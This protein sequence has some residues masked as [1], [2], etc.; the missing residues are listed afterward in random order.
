MRRAVLVAGALVAGGALTA[1]ALATTPGLNGLIAFTAARTTGGDIYTMP[2]G[3]DPE[4]QRTS[5]VEA[6]D[7]AAWSPDGTRFAF[8]RNDNGE[9]D[10][11]IAAADGTNVVPFTTTPGADIDP[12]WSPDGTRIAW[13]SLRDGSDLEIFSARLDGTGLVQHTN[14]GAFFDDEPAWSPDG[15]AIAFRSGRSM[16]N[17]HR[18]AASGTEVD[19]RQV[20]TTPGNAPSWSPDGT[21]IAFD[22]VR[23]GAQSNIFSL[24]AGGTP[25]GT[26][27]AETDLRRHTT[28]P[29]G[30]VTPS[31]SPDGTRIAFASF[32]TSNWDIWTTGYPGTENAPVQ[33]TTSPSADTNPSWQ[34][35]AALPSLAAI[36]PSTA[37]AGS[38]ALTLTV[39][40]AG[41]TPRSRV[42]WQ[43]QDRATTFVS[44]TRLTAAIPASDLAGPGTAQV[45]VVTGPTGGG[46]SGQLPFTVQAPPPAPGLTVAGAA[47]QNRW[48]ASRL[49]GRLV[50]TGA[51]TRPAVLR[52]RVLRPNGRGKALVTRTFRATA[53]GPFTRRL[54][55]APTLLPGRYL[56]RLTEVGSGPGLLPVAE[57]RAVV[58][59]PREGVAARAYFSTKI[60]GRALTRIRG[61]SIIFA[62][63]RMAARPKPG[64]RLTV[65]WYAPGAK[66]PAAV[67]RKPPSA[68][69]IAFIKGSGPLPRGA[70]RAVLRYG[71]TRVATARVVV[72]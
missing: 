4:T 63:F 65:S 60:N 28:D 13:A 72:R 44:S 14:N 11:F 10:I 51:V 71:T 40:G 19:A 29:N 45:T 69:V 57:R 23:P 22:S 20:T 26:A 9:E 17:I 7:D 62:H 53:A 34:T 30:A 49:R 41:F 6:D 47:V 50:L 31:W 25:V 52:V 5:T 56:V 8:T 15:S 33:L 48:T 46:T 64:K 66:R 38:A 3:G 59:A 18:V 70:W 43:G 68:L 55:L 27:P 37:P 16:G 42:R 67:D 39:D 58:P 1:P 54:A 36:T 12:A 61:R 32:R 35:V 21:R 24:P 2:P